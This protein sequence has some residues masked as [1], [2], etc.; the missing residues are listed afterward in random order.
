MRVYY[1]HLQN[2]KVHYHRCAVNILCCFPSYNTVH[3]YDSMKQILHDSEFAFNIYSNLTKPHV[4]R[5]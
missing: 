1:P 4:C 2:P 5:N 3:S